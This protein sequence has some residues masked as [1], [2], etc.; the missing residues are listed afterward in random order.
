VFAESAAFFDADFRGQADFLRTHFQGHALFVGVTF[1]DDAGFE[2]AS[3]DVSGAFWRSM[4]NAAARFGGATFSGEVENRR[5]A[6]FEAAVFASDLSLRQAVVNGSMDLRK[7]A[8]QGAWQL[9]PCVV[10][11]SA[12]L[13]DA[14]FEQP[15]RIEIEAAEVR[16]VRT[17][18]HSSVHMRLRSARVD[19][20][21]A[22][23]G[24]PSILGAAQNQLVAEEG[25]VFEPVKL[26]PPRPLGRPWLSSLARANIASLEVADIDLQAC[27]FAGAHGLDGVRI[28]TPNLFSRSPTWKISRWLVVLPVVWRWTQRQTL[29]EE[30]F[31]RAKYGRGL[32]R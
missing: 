1:E 30:H 11:T 10:R 22:D 3:F 14:V 24:K 7:C 28:E 6:N 16:A 29:A 17:Q 21:D 2:G 8:I 9:G 25:L 19:L 12:L 18:F 13:D 23:F 15:I 20:S 26:G 32:R 5:A 27:R 31:W 4:F